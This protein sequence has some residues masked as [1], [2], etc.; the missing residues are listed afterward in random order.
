MPTVMHNVAIF[1]LINIGLIY[2]LSV[3]ASALLVSTIQAM[4]RPQSVG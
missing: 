4:R 3:W 1:I 2:A